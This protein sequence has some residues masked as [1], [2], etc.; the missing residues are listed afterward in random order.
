MIKKWIQK[1]LATTPLATAAMDGFPIPWVKDSVSIYRFLA[2]F[3]TPPSQS[4]PDAALELPDED[5]VNKRSGSKLRWAAGALDGVFGHHSRGDEQANIMAIQ[6]ALLSAATNPTINN[7]RTLYNMLVAE[8]A[9]VSL[10]PLLQNIR[11]ATHLPIARLKALARWL[12]TESPDRAAVKFGIALLGLFVPAEDTD[13]LVTLGLHEEFTLYTVVALGSTLEENKVEATWWALAKRVHGWGR[14][15]IVERLSNTQRGDIRSWLL[16][17]GYKNSVMYEYLA[18]SCAV[19]G[20][21]LGALESEQIDDDLLIGAGEIIEALINGGPA[22]DIYCY[23][24]GFKAVPLYLFKAAKAR[25]KNLKVLVAVAR[26]RD[27]VTD[28]DLDQERVEALGWTAEVREQLAIACKLFIAFDYWPAV[29]EDAWS[30]HDN[31]TFWTA[32]RAGEIIGLEVWGKR[33]ERQ[34]AKL[35]EQWYYLMQTD[36]P[37][38]IQLVIDLLVTQF[39]L[40][41]IATGPAEE[42]GFGPGC[43]KYS[44]IDSVLQELGR[45]PGMGWPLIQTGL[46]SP[47]IRNRNMA[48]RA[49]KEWGVAHWPGGTRE[50]LERAVGDEPYPDTRKFLAEALALT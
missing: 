29:V 19:G 32:A 34:K 18:Y 23:E 44:A 10:D 27:F 3:E 41:T 4:L 5:K 20:D 42:M 31:P 22:E 2:A 36:D 7:V 38:R 28:D 16:R 12:A 50:M 14:I 43:E 37:A 25:T 33:F 26:I 24:D 13:T 35:S 49:L 45:F 30:S 40:A 15:Q 47:V 9:L 11:G 46:R 8:N 6:A 1:I 17:E 48:I 21:L 39:D